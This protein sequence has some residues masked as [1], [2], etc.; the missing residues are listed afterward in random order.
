MSLREWPVRRVL[1]IS[2]AWV[3]AALVFF[4]A[5][6]AHGMAV[7][8]QQ[9]NGIGAVSFGIAEALACVAAPPLFLTLVWYLL[10]R[11]L[12]SDGASG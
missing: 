5:W 10:R 8:A 6:T 9:G 7:Q 4:V 3:V 2:V 11:P 12:A 1:W